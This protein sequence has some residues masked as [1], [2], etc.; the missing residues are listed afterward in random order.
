[1]KRK[2]DRGAALMSRRT[3]VAATSAA[4]AASALPSWPAVSQPADKVTIGTSWQAEAEHGGFYQALAT[5]LYKK[6]GL[7]VTIR[8]GGPQLNTAQMLAANAVDFRVGS[9]SGG[10][11]NYVQ[12]GVPAMAVAAFF[13]KEPTVLIAHPDVG[14]NSI[15]DMKGKPIAIS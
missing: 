9:N 15:A 8:Q 13:Q 6:H 2:Q 5:G 1:M 14:I 11:L 7:D 3:F 12:N 10:T 4:A